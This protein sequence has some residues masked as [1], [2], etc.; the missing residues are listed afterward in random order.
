[1]IHCDRGMYLATFHDPVETRDELAVY[2]KY[3]GTLRNEVL[4]AY[5]TGK[6]LGEIKIIVKLDEISYLDNYDEYFLTN[7]EFAN[8][9][10]I[11]I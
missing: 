6:N 2:G 3:I 4:A 11:N 1:M 10:A 5:Q 8:D 9:Q 7:L